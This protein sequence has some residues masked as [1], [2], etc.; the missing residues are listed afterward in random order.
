[1]MLFRK[2]KRG[3]AL[4][5]SILLTLTS[6]PFSSAADTVDLTVAE[7][8][9]GNS[10]EAVFKEKTGEEETGEEDIVK[11][12]TE[13]EEVKEDDS[14]TSLNEEPESENGT[15]RD[16][17]NAEE[18]LKNGNANGS[19][20]YVMTSANGS[21]AARPVLRVFPLSNYVH[22]EPIANGTI[23]I[24]TNVEV[25]ITSDYAYGSNLY[26]F[27]VEGDEKL[28]EYIKSMIRCC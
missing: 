1:M 25:E 24:G 3:T 5:L 6:V 12:V 4:F 16:K 17:N 28:K 11:E 13:I 19:S 9:T 15:D 20:D 21:Q 7:E 18:S 22:G 27:K 26:M 23:D 2:F 14:N 8:K 10:Q